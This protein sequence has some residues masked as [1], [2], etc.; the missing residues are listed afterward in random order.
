MENRRLMDIFKEQKEEILTNKK[1]LEETVNKLFLG[2]LNRIEQERMKVLG[3][4]ER[5][6]HLQKENIFSIEKRLILS[7]QTQNNISK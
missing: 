3:F 6:F 7:T 1:N 2:L 5:Q 4:V